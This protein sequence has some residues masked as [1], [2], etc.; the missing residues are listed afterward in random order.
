MSLFEVIIALMIIGI[1]ATAMGGIL[2]TAIQGNRINKDKMIAINLAREGLE[3]VG[4]IVA[5]NWLKF[6][7]DKDH[8]WDLIKND[9]SV[10]DCA[11]AAHFSLNSCYLVKQDPN[12]RLFA[13]SKTCPSGLLTEDDDY[14]LYLKDGL[15]KH[16][17]SGIPQ[18]FFRLI[19]I[20]D[21]NDT[22]MTV[23]STVSWYDSGGATHSVVFTTTL[24]NYQQ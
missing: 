20:T 6:S 5:T 16:E 7:T 15:Y 4:E 23:S 17:S 1:I 12:Y 22:S 10:T 2:V 3:A 13:E 14:K 19:K 18:R 21:K 9:A 8:C 11:V 24:T